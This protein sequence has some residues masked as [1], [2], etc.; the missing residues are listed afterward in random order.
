MRTILLLLCCT[1]TA[2]GQSF[3]R[4]PA[5]Q[6]AAAL[7]GTPV[8][9]A[10]PAGPSYAGPTWVTNG[11]FTSGAA[12][13]TPGLPTGYAANDIF[14]LF[15]ESEN[16][17]SSAIAPPTGWSMVTNQSGLTNGLGALNGASS[18]S[19]ETFWKRATASETAPSV[20]DRGDYALAQI[21]CIRGAESNAYPFHAVQV[22]NKS[23]SSKT[24][25]ITNAT[26]TISNCLIVLATSAMFDGSTGDNYS[27]WYNPSLTNLAER[28]DV[29]TIT[30]SGG[31]MANL[32]GEQWVQGEFL[33]TTGLV[34]TT[35]VAI[36]LA[37][38]VMPVQPIAPMIITQPSNQS[39]QT[40]ANATFSIVA[41][42][43][44]LPLT[45]RWQTNSVDVANSAGRWGG[46]TA[47]SLILTNALLTD[48]NTLVR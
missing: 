22:D 2:C 23:G 43:G 38:A 42:G 39:V 7:Q 30:A 12:A 29:G 8:A 17:A 15:V 6:G 20:E 35:T 31:V 26:T 41:S 45:Y 9:A 32:T 44:T 11:A 33:L 34:D 24:V 14:I 27:D 40:N 21:M 36:N 19:L 47:T 16:G 37:A 10:P 48:S 28:G 3:I 18:T 13:V 1:L 25:S 46:S 5:F 4:S